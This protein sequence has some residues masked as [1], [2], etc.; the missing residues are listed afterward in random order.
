MEWAIFGFLCLVFLTGS[1]L[2][3]FHKKLIYSILGFLLITLVV[4]GAMAALGAEIP[5]VSQIL[6]YSGGL[7]VLLLFA[8]MIWANT[9]DSKPRY[10]AAAAFLALL[11]MWLFGNFALRFLELPLNKQDTNLKEFSEYLFSNYFLPFELLGV[12]LLLVLIGSLYLV[13][14]SKD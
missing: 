2:V 4:A 9:P 5:A 7:V 6:I 11:M 1:Y 10:R 12:L 14:D 8:L 3:V 13:F